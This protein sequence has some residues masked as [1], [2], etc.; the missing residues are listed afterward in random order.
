M[1]GSYSYKEVHFVFE[2]ELTEVCAFI[3]ADEN[4]PMGVQG[5]HHKTF[6]ASMSAVDILNNEI[7]DAVTWPLDTRVL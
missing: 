1:N 3:A 6:P 7:K 2:D 5:C 4:C